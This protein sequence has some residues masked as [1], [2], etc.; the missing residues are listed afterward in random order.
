MVEKILLAVPLIAL[1]VVAVAC[2][3]SY[4]TKRGKSELPR[5][6]AWLGGGVVFAVVSALT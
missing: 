5:W 6:V 1:S 2:I 3:D 4:R